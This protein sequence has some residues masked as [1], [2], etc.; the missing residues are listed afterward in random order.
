MA[1]VPATSAIARPGRHELDVVKRDPGRRVAA[2]F[3][4]A[5]S[6]VTAGSTLWA[7]STSL[8]D[9]TMSMLLTVVAGSSMTVLLAFLTWRWSVGRSPFQRVVED[10]ER[11]A[12]N[13]LPLDRNF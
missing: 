3:T 13:R 6:A 8:P 12:F 4:G 2:V 7:V 5:G 1:D 10:D 11:K 9:P